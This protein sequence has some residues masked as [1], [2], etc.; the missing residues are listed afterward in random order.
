MS[1]KQ[2][3]KIQ[4]SSDDSCFDRAR[5]MLKAAA[6]IDN[7]GLAARM[8]E[9]VDAYQKLDRKAFHAAHAQLI[10]EL[11]E[12]VDELNMEYRIF[13]GESMDLASHMAD[14]LQHLAAQFKE[15]NDE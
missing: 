7:G 2:E 1:N 14:R 5:K 15:Q 9:A 4:L 12:V 6:V 3:D 10:K 8:A 11:V 13:E